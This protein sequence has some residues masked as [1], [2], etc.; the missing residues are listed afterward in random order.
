M[1][2]VLNSIFKHFTTFLII[3]TT[4]VVLIIWLTIGILTQTKLQELL[5]GVMAVIAGGF[6]ISGGIGWLFTKF[7]F[8]QLMNNERNSASSSVNMNIEKSVEYEL[9][10]DDI[11]GFH[12]FNY[13][14]YNRARHIIRLLIFVFILEILLIISILTFIGGKWL[15]VSI[16]I[17]ILAIITILYYFFAPFFLRMA[18][19]RRLTKNYQNSNKLIGKHR[20]SILPIGFTDVTAVG[21]QTTHWDSVGYVA[22]DGIHLFIFV[23]DNGPFIVPRTAFTDDSMFMEFVNLAKTY[24]ELAS[25]KK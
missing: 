8:P 21:E 3:F 22:S 5:I 25:S 20:F 14:Q 7:I 19:R 15:F 16:I 13:R 6:A 17:G 18:I 2:N 4:S 11:I 23:R 24:H 1:V 12:L 10:E 9:R